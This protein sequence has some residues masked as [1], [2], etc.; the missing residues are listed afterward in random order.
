MH[1]GQ[2]RLILS[3]FMQW[4]DKRIKGLIGHVAP[5][6]EKRSKVSSFGLISVLRPFNTF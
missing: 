1:F 5:S 2:W 4:I 3:M 6:N